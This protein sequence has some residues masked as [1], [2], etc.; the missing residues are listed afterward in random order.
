M[1]SHGMAWLC[2]T[3]REILTLRSGEFFTTLEY[4]QAYSADCIV[5]IRSLTNVLLTIAGG[6]GERDR[7]V[8]VCRCR[9]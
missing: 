6:G 1:I 8:G 3:D 9:R 4:R 7:A 2:F 5:Y